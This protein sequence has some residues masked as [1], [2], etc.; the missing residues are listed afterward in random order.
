MGDAIGNFV[1][2]LLAFL[3]PI[4][5]PDWGALVGMLP[6]FLLIGVVGPLL[7]LLVLGWL[8]YVVRRP[9]ARMPR[10]SL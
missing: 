8:V 10:R 9:R 4:L 6:I 3:S 7:S 1:K 2:G 5:S